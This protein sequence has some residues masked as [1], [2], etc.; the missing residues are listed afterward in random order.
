MSTLA[1]FLIV[2]GVLYSLFM[3]VFILSIMAGQTEWVIGSAVV[4][5]VAEAALII[6]AVFVK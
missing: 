2:S 6:R 3:L 1:R 5:G 4:Y